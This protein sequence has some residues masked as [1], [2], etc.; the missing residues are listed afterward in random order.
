MNKN[1]LISGQNS[2]E[3]KVNKQSSAKDLKAEDLNYYK[4]EGHSWSAE[5]CIAWFVER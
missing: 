5:T 2:E 4:Q 1:K 3:K